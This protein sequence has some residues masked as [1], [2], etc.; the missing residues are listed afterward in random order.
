VQLAAD[1]AGTTLRTEH[2]KAAV[3]LNGTLGS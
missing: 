3:Y 2:F 1:G